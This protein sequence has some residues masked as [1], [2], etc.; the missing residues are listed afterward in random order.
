MK[1]IL[2]RL[3]WCVLVV[4]N[5]A[6]SCYDRAPR[7]RNLYPSFSPDGER[8]AYVHNNYVGDDAGA[9][10]H[11]Y[12]TGIYVVDKNGN[13]RT[14]VPL[15]LSFGAYDITAL[16]WSPDGTRLAFIAG[17]YRTLYVSGIDG[18]NLKSLT[19][20]YFND[21]SWSPDS[22]YILYS[23][24]DDILKYATADLS[25]HDNLFHLT[26]S[27][28]SPVLSPDGKKVLYALPAGFP[29]EV[30]IA[31]STNSNPQSVKVN[32]SFYNSFVWSPNGKKFAYTSNSQ[33]EGRAYV[34]SPDGTQNRLVG[35]GVASSWSVQDEI[36]LYDDGL[37][38]SD[39][40]V[41]SPD[42]AHLRQVTFGD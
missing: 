37:N 5:L 4:G 42:G 34:I 27:G 32:F 7:I 19:G 13:D 28:H 8:I 26:L 6:M 33:N 16:K 38:I 17:Y 25:T 11:P 1:R 41:A 15:D 40:F 12:P 29:G 22:Q 20:N 14:Q 9:G 24:E 18:S 3:F 36:A 10:I 2:S 35:S 30:I 23:D 39:I 21:I 31:D